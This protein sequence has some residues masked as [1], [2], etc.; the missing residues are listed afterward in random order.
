MSNENITRWSDKKTFWTGQINVETYN[1]TSSAR[2][3]II[4]DS[5]GDVISS[6]GNFTKAIAFVSGTS[7]QEYIGLARPGTSKST[8]GWQIKKLIYDGYKITDIQW[9]DGTSAF[10]KIWEDRVTYNYS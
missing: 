7:K 10:T 6:L 8:N 5:S 3:V 4:V 9:A 2:R 1:E